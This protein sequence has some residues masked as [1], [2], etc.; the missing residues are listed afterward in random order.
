MKNIKKK[1]LVKKASGGPMTAK[2]GL[3]KVTPA[4]SKTTGAKV[5]E[6]YRTAPIKTDT[7]NTPI[8]QKL[9]EYATR[10]PEPKEYSKYSELKKAA[11]QPTMKK[12]GAMKKVTMMKKGGSM[13]SVTIKKKK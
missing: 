10:G 6:S 5:G 8:R 12:G 11:A 7:V 13:K 2:P 9:S 1:I 4:Q 3:S